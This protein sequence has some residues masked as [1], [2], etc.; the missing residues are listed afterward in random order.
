MVK[1]VK[2]NSQTQIIEQLKRQGPCSVNDLAKSLGLSRNTVNHHI[3]HLEKSGWLESSLTP[4]GV[5]RPA[6]K[7]ALN[8]ASE[9]LFPKRYAQLLEAVLVVAEEESSLKRLL[10]GVANNMVK[11]LEPHLRGLHGEAR[12]KKLLER[13]DY[14]DMLPELERIETGFVLLAHNC[15]YR[16]TGAK[17]EGVC[18]LLPAV[19][20]G[21]TGW[22][23]ERPVCQRDGAR[24]CQFVVSNPV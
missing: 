21:L 19:I 16:A 8:L 24:A 2:M 7:Y 4:T 20:E 1:I 18:D 22:K 12:L 11:E 15:V 5:G 10:L 9:N 13:V 17:F 14:G 23:A 3:A 6:V